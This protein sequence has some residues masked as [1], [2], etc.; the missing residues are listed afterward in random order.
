MTLETIIGLLSFCFFLFLA[1][2]LLMWCSK[3]QDKGFP[4]S[5]GRK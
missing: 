1:I 4:H 2:W 3:E 5:R